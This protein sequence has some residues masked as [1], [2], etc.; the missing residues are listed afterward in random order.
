VAT[1]LN[2]WQKIELAGVARQLDVCQDQIEELR[3]EEARLTAAIV[4]KMKPGAIEGIAR[5]RLEMDYPAGR[6]TE[7]SFDPGADQEI[8]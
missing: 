8:E 4:F 3:E 1:L 6:L 2:I 7:L 5:G